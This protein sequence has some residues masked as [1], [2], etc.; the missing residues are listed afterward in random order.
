MRVG[1]D[2]DN[3][4]INYS[5]VFL[6]ICNKYNLKIN[7][8]NPKVKLKNYI[9]KNISKEKWTEIQGKVYGKEILTAN[10]F[11]NFNSFIRFAKRNNIDVT[12]ISHKSK[13]PIL[14]KKINL[15]LKALNF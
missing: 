14:G 3:T 10:I 13:Y 4:I 1:I 2:L 6:K 8:E 9:R 7:K 15:H 5:K 12:I 11:Q